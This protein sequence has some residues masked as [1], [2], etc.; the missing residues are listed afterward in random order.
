M[1]FEG[2]WNVSVRF[3]FITDA[4]FEMEIACIIA[5]AWLLEPVVLREE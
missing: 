5:S 3:R 2:L 4:E 1:D